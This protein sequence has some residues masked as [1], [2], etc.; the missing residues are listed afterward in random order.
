MGK[1]TRAQALSDLPITEE[2]AAGGNLKYSPQTLWLKSTCIISQFP[3]LRNP[4]LAIVGSPGCGSL[5]AV[6]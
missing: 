3:W 4:G 5:E 2:E 1:A 6:T